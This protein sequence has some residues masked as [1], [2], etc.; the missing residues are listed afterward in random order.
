VPAFSQAVAKLKKGTYTKKPV[1]TKFGW[2]AIYLEETRKREPP[3]FDTVKRQLALILQNKRVKQ[4]VDKLRL[5][6]K[7]EITK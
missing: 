6:A 2:H 3:T 4:Y 5:N 1:K 7:I